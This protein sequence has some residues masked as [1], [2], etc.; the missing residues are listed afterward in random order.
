MRWSN[1]IVGV[2]RIRYK[3]LSFDVLINIED[4]LKIVINLFNRTVKPQVTLSSSFWFYGQRPRVWPLITKLS[5]STL[6]LFVFRFFPAC[7]FGKFDDFGFGGVRS[8]R[9]KSLFTMF[10]IHEPL[11]EKQ[12]GSKIPTPHQKPWLVPEE[13]AIITFDPIRLG[14]SLLFPAVF[15][16]FLFLSFCC[17]MHILFFILLLNR[18]CSDIFAIEHS[19]RDG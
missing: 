12:M 11:R 6:V 7:N 13:C 18:C 14:G 2:E 4:F 5:I 10:L 1:G 15:R 19:C 17:E 16:Q 8:E 9:I 3:E